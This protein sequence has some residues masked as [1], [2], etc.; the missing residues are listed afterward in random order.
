MVG[1]RCVRLHGVVFQETVGFIV[2]A[3][4][5]SYMRW[6]IGHKVLFG[7]F[8]GALSG[9]QCGLHFRERSPSEGTL[10]RLTRVVD[11]LHVKEPHIPKG[12]HWANLVRTFPSDVVDQSHRQRG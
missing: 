6:N 9:L 1:L 5:A 2:A 11:L 7:S 10:S 3:V 12:S 8:K 4:G